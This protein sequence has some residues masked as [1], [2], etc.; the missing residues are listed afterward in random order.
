MRKKIILLFVLMPVLLMAQAEKK[1]D[2]WE[3][4]KFLLGK[5]EGQGDG[6]QEGKE[7]EPRFHFHLQPDIRHRR[8]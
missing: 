3:P 6:K 7:L 1:Q 4:M 2:I 5:W 8:G